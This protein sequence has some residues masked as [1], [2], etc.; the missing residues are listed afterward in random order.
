MGWE[1]QA[2]QIKMM[3]NQ[4]PKEGEA[5]TDQVVPRGQRSDTEWDMKA[6]GIKWPLLFQE[7]SFK[8][9]ERLIIRVRN[10]V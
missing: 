9:K 8:G 2:M 3:F 6:Q 5:K 7:L 1:E 10:G 4:M